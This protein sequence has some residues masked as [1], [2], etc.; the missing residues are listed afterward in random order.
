[1]A[2]A[3]QSLQIGLAGQN[4]EITGRGEINQGALFGGDQVEDVVERAF[5][6]AI[7]QHQA[8][9]RLTRHSQVFGGVIGEA[10]ASGWRFNGLGGPCADIVPALLHAKHDG[11]GVLAVGEILLYRL[12]CAVGI[13]N[14]DSAA[15]PEKIVYPVTNGRAVRLVSV[16]VS[17]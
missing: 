15:A 8:A 9:F 17:K 13:A 6:L 10:F 1:L 11:A 12:V 4:V 14:Q 7:P 3:E 16:S 5:A 2:V